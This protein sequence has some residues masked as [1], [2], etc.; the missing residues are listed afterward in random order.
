LVDHN[1]VDQMTPA[2]KYDPARMK[3]IAGLIDHHALAPSFTTG[4]PLWMDVRP[5]GSM[6][7]IVFVNFLR[8]RVPVDKA[9]ARLLLCAILSDTLNLKSGTTT[10]ADR[11]CVALLATFGEVEDIDELAKN[12]FKAKTN[13]IVSLGSYE[14][15]RGD[16]KNFTVGKVR[17]SIAVLE[18]TDMAPVFEHAEDLLTQMRVFKYEKGDYVDE[19]SQGK[20]HDV[21]K[22]CHCA[23]LFVVDTINQC[24][25]ALICGSREKWVAEKAFPDGVFSAAAEGIRAP[26]VLTSANDTQ[27]NVGKLSSR[28]LEFLP[29][30]T[31]ALESNEP[32]EWFYNTSKD[33]DRLGR[34]LKSVLVDPLVHTSVQ[35]LWDKATIKAAV[36]N[37]TSELKKLNRKLTTVSEF[38]R[39][40]DEIIDA[41]GVLDQIVE[42]AN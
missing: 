35:V 41:Q 25:V 1:E 27:C 14:M 3:R 10:P 11:F 22:E 39:T 26:S 29:K 32:P 28:K 20:A 7:S 12:L 40:A 5:W 2:L 42:E 6:S 16:Q 17:L 31:E 15:V 13:W 19:E 33:M 18:V 30:I 23:M 24:S 36:F 8:N 21:S 34:V 38:L 37:D 4:S 9:M